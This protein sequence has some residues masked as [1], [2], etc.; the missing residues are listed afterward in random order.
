MTVT[1]R[2]TAEEFTAQMVALNARYPEAKQIR[3]IQD[4]LSTHSPTALYQCLPPE[5]ANRLKKRFEWIYTPKHASW[6]N[7]A[8]ME[9]SV[10]ERQCLG[11]RLASTKALEREVKAWESERNVKRVKVN[12]QFTTQRARVKMIGRYSTPKITV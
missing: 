10:L 5:E 7:M 3:L 6:L 9:W 11:Q 8:E 12:W 2:R 1:E 4:N